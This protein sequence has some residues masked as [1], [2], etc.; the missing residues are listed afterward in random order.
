MLLGG[1]QGARNA[2]ELR[3]SPDGVGSEISRSRRNAARALEPTAISCRDQV[4]GTTRLAILL[5]G[6]TGFVGGALAVELLRAGH[7]LAAVVR[8]RDEDAARARVVESLARFIDV[9]AARSA[10]S[11]MDLVVGDL[12]EVETY[13]H[14]LFDRLTHVAHA[15]GCTSFAARAEV[16]RTN[17]EGSEM[18]ARRL[19]DA[20]ALRRFLHVSTAYACG[21]VSTPVI[22]E[23]DAPRPGRRYVNEYS[24]SKAEAELRLA[25][26]GLGERLVVARP[27]IVIG[28]TRLGVRP[29]SSLFWFCRAMAALGQGPFELGDARDIVPVDYV[30]EALSFLLLGESLR[31][32]TYHV[33]AG[34]AGSRSLREMLL[35]LGW[36]ESDGWRKVPAD[37]LLGLRAELRPLAGGELEARKLARG[38]AACARFGELGIQYFDNRRLLAEG[39][40]GPPA[41]ADYAAVCQRTSEGA[42]VYEQMIDEA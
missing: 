39:F 38:L 20:P 7:Q 3:Y 5:T 32:A 15:A 36:R 6:V 25:E 12:G 16:W 8:A 24:R 13:R 18:L 40:R 37:A 4:A 29:S 30:A 9:D 17:V 19:R 31:A 42:S 21:E 2:Q 26:L 14:A 11:A 35:A 27:S 10:A 22:H 41:F 1:R 28:H 34:Q 23:D 33:S